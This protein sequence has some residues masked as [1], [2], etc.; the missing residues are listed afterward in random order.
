MM[1]THGH[2]DQSCSLV[3]L[4]APSAGESSEELGVSVSPCYN[5]DGGSSSLSWNATSELGKSKISN[6]SK[7]MA[8]NLA[9]SP[10]F[11]SAVAVGRI[12]PAVGVDLEYIGLLVRFLYK[13]GVSMLSRRCSCTDGQQ[14]GPSEADGSKKVG[15]GATSVCL[16]EYHH[17]PTIVFIN[18]FR[19]PRSITA[20][21]YVELVVVNSAC[22]SAHLEY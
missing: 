17:F 4:V 1:V 14:T 13:V 15:E 10:S 19:G 2:Q 12:H 3:A 6:D 22:A 8:T 21:Q 18:F 7:G 9:C 20:R 16:P 5:D 11:P